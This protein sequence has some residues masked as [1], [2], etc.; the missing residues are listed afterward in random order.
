MPSPIG[1]PRDP[2]DGRLSLLLV[3]PPPHRRTLG[4]PARRRGRR[5]RGG[6]AAAS[7]AKT[8][9]HTRASSGTRAAA[10]GAC[11]ASG[12]CGRDVRAKPAA[13]VAG[14]S[15]GEQMQAEFEPRAGGARESSAVGI[16]I[17]PD[18]RA[19]P[20]GSRPKP[21]GVEVWH[22]ISRPICTL[23]EI[24]ARGTQGT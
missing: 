14:E 1:R 4:A 8:R 11:A 19:P 24:V 16:E 13:M 12:G 18:A 20:G 10:W 23:P 6:R 21:S 9:R 15:G 22:V 17:E 3:L 7:C 5:R 2:P